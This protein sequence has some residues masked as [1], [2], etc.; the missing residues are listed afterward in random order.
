MS[1]K[2]QILLII[3]AALLAACGRTAT[4]TQ[5]DIIPEPVFQVQKEGS[6]TLNR[7]SKD[8]YV[9]RITNPQTFW[10]T[11]KYLVVQVK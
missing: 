6:Y 5:I 2:N 8:Q 9:L 1:L 7:D 3:A 11:S 4:V 10:S